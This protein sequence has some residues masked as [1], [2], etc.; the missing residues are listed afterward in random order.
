MSNETLNYGRRLSGEEYDHAIVALYSDLPPKPSWAQR[1]EVRRQELNLTLDYRLGLEFPLKKREALWAVQ[2][3]IEKHRIKIMFT[4]LLRRFFAKNLIREAKGLAGYVIE[5][6]AKVLNQA[7][8]EQFFGE[9][10]VRHP[11][12]PVELEQLKK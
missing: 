9:E 12:L 11:A 7:E 10:E 4:Y 3:E 1:K 8:L 5:A 6:Y 2:Q